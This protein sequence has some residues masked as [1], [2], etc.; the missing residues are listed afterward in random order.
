MTVSLSGPTDTVKLNNGVEMPWLG[1]GTWQASEGAEVQDAV[2]HALELGYR[3]IDTASIYGNERGVGAALR[4]SGVPRDDVFITTKVWNEDVRGGHDRVLRAFDASLERL[5]LETVDLYLVHWPVAD[6]FVEAWRALE[7]LYADGR[8]RAIGVSNFLRHHLKALLADCHVV[9]AVNQIE[10]HPRL[11][12]PDLLAFCREHGI[13]V[14]AWSPIMKGRV[15]QVPELREIGERHGKTAAQV[16]LRWNLQNGVVTI[17]KS[18]HRER[19]AE[20]A[21]LFDFE[22][23]DDEMATIA[24]L[25]RGERI[26]ADPDHI[27]F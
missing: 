3:H 12:Q 22:L 24:S 15:L 26:G 4:D 19:I 7:K 8:V 13:V 10:H 11:Q 16:T 27:P 20:N 6:R 21:D 2:R 25:D 23:S 9:P 14:E 17:P 5:G 1:L 18:V